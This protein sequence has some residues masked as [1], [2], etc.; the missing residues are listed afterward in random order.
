MSL[1]EEAYVAALSS[2]YGFGYKTVSSFIKCFGSAGAVWKAPEGELKSRGYS[3][4]L[5]ERFISERK[6]INVGKM[7][8]DI[9]GQG[10]TLLNI[11][12]GEYPR[13]LKLVANPPV[14][15]YVKGV[16][17]RDCL[18]KIAVVG[19]RRPTVYGTKFARKIASDLARQNICIV[20]GMA[21]GIDTSA[22]KGA[23][24]VGGRTLAVL[25]CGVDVVY[26]TENR[27]LALE[28]QEHGALISE[29]PLG[30]PPD[31][32]NFPA[33]NRIISGLSSGVV[34]VEAPARSGA[35]ITADFA[36]DQG[37][38][39][40]AVPG[41]VT[42]KNSEGCNRLI[43]DGAKLVE[44]VKDILE[45]LWDVSTAEVMTAT[46]LQKPDQEFNLDRKTKEILSLL[47]GGPVFPDDL[48]THAGLSPAELNIVITK[49]ELNGLVAKSGGR[50]F[51]VDNN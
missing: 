39:V 4:A 28:I 49:L 16:L 33:R 45:D 2:I 32:K 1:P 6:K 7:F 24:D 40:F 26:P 43:K 27:K 18:M 38:E 30:T 44:D 47:K 34:V 17:P 36:L 22:H 29:F 20:S 42:S 21:R 37:R 3:E 15:L 5:V 8:E 41:P 50:I 11:F 19:T 23:I 35:L 46:R 25:G 48:C 31:K 51:A 12:E 13:E 10:V 9:Q 14:L